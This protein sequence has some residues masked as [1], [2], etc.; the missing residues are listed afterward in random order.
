MNGSQYNFSEITLIRRIR[1]HCVR[2]AR[3]DS[4]PGETEGRVCQ[5]REALIQ[6]KDDCNV[7]LK[8]Y[9]E[10]L[11]DYICFGSGSN[12]GRNPRLAILKARYG[13]HGQEE[14]LCQ[15]AMIKAFKSICQFQQGMV[16]WPWLKCVAESVLQDA[17]KQETHHIQKRSYE[18]I[19]C[20]FANDLEIV[21]LRE[22]KQRNALKMDASVIKRIRNDL[23][24]NTYRQFQQLSYASAADNVVLQHIQKTLE[25][26]CRPLLLQHIS[27]DTALEIGE[28]ELTDAIESPETLVL[29]QAV[30]L[31]ALQVAFEKC[32]PHQALILFWTTLGYRPSEV[33]GLFSK[34]TLNQLVDA[35]R[36]QGTLRFEL[37]SQE[38]EQ[39]CQTIMDKL[40]RPYGRVEQ[41]GRMRLGEFWGDDPQGDIQN[42][43]RRALKKMQ[44]CLCGEKNELGLKE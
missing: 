2:L 1:D 31:K 42:W 34:L 23:E 41:L 29:Q 14:D 12:G 28:T 35:M 37:W 5:K 15:E 20:Q 30:A 19:R 16:I 8:R 24:Q 3:F 9:Q 6:L 7:L 27:L 18:A 26:T 32:K 44:D 22:L 33:V 36:E 39:I 17:I 10:R 25:D 4:I 40:Q 21:L 38:F 43:S 11:M 13:D